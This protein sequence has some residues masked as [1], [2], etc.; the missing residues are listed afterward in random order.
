MDNK[1]DNKYYADKIVA[2]LEFII[3]H[4]KDI[5]IKDFE[6]NEILVDSVMF[7]LIQVSENSDRL[8]EAFK[9]YHKTIPWR[10]LKGMRN[11]IV[12]EY[13]NVDMSVIYDTVKNDIPELLKELKQITV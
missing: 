1:K 10:A 11:K 9:A 6:T 2:D 12:N 5:N 3:K 7:R 13:G 8:S 4:T